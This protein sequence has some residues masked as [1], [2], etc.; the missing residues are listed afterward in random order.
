[1]TDP[2]FRAPT[3]AWRHAR[4]QES[5]RAL[6][7]ETPV[8]ITYDRVSFAVMMATPQNLTDFAIG[9]SLSEGI[10]RDVADIEEL[11]IVEVEAGIECRMSLAP[12]RRDVLA[13]RR[14]NIAGP[15]GC[16]LCGLD[17]LKEAARPIKQVTSNLR[18][19]G[20]RIAEGFVRLARA[21]TLNRETRAVHAAAFCTG[22]KLI[23]REDVG[24]H[25]ALDKVLGA[26]MQQDVRPGAG[27]VLLTSRVSI[28]LIQ[29]TAAF[30][31]AILA[32]ISVPTARAV[33][34]AD[35]AGITL[36]AVARDDGFEIFTHPERIILE[37]QSD[38]A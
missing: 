16:G 17:S 4:Q 11:D 5:S 21:Q 15:V 36:I 6:P 28:E 23:V 14:R 31:T 9:F 10:I 3:T 1:M 2:V 29:K 20:R 32:A 27:I 33:R 19:P 7:E 35:A 18:V 22:K 13:T 34:E 24:R 25:N 37:S 12:E 38:V 26:A 30:G 8:A